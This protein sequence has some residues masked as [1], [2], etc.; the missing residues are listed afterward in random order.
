[1]EELTALYNLLP[2]RYLALAG[3]VFA[4]CVALRTLLRGVVAVCYALDFA[5]DGKY[6]W[7][8]VGKM[9]DAID[10]FDSALAKSRW[11][12]AKAIGVKGRL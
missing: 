7:Q 3:T 4:A 1:M 11:F 5:L 8:W 12:P 2:E 6:D 9:G 10:R